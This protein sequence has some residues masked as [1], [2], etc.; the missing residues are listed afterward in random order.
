MAYGS[1]PMFM[2]DACTVGLD[3]AGTMRDALRGLL[4]EFP[5]EITEQLGYYVYRLIDPRNGETFYVGKGRG[6]RVFHHVSANL[7]Q[8]ELAD[9]EDALAIKMRRV[10]EIRSE[11]LQV[12][13]VIQRHGLTE[14][15]AFHVEGALIDA[16]PGL[17]NV[18]SGHGNSDKG[19]MHADAIVRKYAAQRLEPDHRIVFFTI[20]RSV[21]TERGAYEGCRGV[22]RM[23]RSRA[24]RADL[25]MP[26]TDGVVVGVFVPERWIDATIV[27][28]PAH[29]TEDLS[30]RIG[31]IGHDAED[32]IRTRYIGKR[33]PANLET[34]T[35]NP[36]R[37]SYS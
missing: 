24:E 25:V 1:W 33:L 31:F 28:F 26:V 2:V 36:V 35:Q 7:K 8:A 22:W 3:G 17:T 20:R 34:G 23:S 18:Q 32:E 21:L 16:F 14:K 29:I 6:N 15:E 5:S 4:Q 12:I 37:Y 9:D 19:A 10:R 11:G 27:S 30:G 13:H